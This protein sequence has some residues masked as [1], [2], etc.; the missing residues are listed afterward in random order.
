M[1]SG[2]M[3]QS[4][5]FGS[6]D[7]DRWLV[8]ASLIGNEYIGRW[9]LSPQVQVADGNEDKTSLGQS[10]SS[11]DAAIGRLAGTMEVG[12]DWIGRPGR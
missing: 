3:I 11:T 9:R 12:Y 2:S 6:F 8:T 4:G 7:T 1:T 5:A 10:V